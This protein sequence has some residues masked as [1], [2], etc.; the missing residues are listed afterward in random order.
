[1]KINRQFQ[2][3]HTRGKSADW[4]VKQHLDRDICLLYHQLANYSYIMRR[5]LLWL[6]FRLGLLEYL[7]FPGGRG[8]STDFYVR[9]SCFR[10]MILAHAPG[11]KH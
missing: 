6:G 10:L 4:V 1:M 11:D 5:S 9:D 3:I 7:D 2:E 8:R